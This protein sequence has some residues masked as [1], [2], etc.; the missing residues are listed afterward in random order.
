MRITQDKF[1]ELWYNFSHLKKK[2]EE[3]ENEKEFNKHINL[4]LDFRY[5]VNSFVNSYRSVTF[6]LQKEHRST[7]GQ[8]FEDWYNSAIKALTEHPFSKTILELRN[9]NQKEGNVEPTFEFVGT[10]EKW[11]ITFDLD[12]NDEKNNFIGKYTMKFKREEKETQAVFTSPETKTGDEFL[13]QEDDLSQADKIHIM[14]LTAQAFNQI[15][16]EIHNANGFRLNA[17]KINRLG[18]EFTP[19]EFLN[20]LMEMGSLMQKLIKDGWK[21][22]N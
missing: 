18:K 11:V 12:P 14:T 19:S 4:V 8:K 21:Q 9:I 1:N 3:I 5:E 13:E 22:L 2:Y 10:T 15:F 7:H 16:T 17:I 6:T 20:N